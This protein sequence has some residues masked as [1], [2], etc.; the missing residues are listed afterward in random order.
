MGQ[1]QPWKVRFHHD[2]TKEFSDDEAMPDSYV[3][4]TSKPIDG[5][6]AH[7]TQADAET[8]ARR[9]SR[10]GGIAHIIL[11]DLNTGRERPVRTYTPYEAAMEDLL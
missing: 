11:R 1:R 7:A 2:G 3:I 4:D 10:N 5:T 8:A 6:T 9:V